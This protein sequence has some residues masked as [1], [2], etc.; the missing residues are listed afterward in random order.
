MGS[1]PVSV[2][3]G[4]RNSQTSAGDLIGD[5]CLHTLH[6]WQAHRK[7]EMLVRTTQLRS[8]HL[9]EVMMSASKQSPPAK[10]VQTANIAARSFANLDRRNGLSE[11]L[12]DPAKHPGVLSYND[13]FV[14][15]KDLY[16]KATVHLLILPRDPVKQNQHPSEAFQDAV[17]FAKLKDEASK[18][19]A[20]AA[21]E[22]ARELCPPT[23]SIPDRN[24]EEE[25]KVGIHSV[26]SMHHLH[27]HVISRD[28]HSPSLKHKKHYNSFNTPFFV[29]LEE[30][31]LTEEEEIA[32]K[33][34]WHKGDMICWR[35]KRNF[36]NKF[37]A[38]KQHLEKEFDEWKAELIKP[39]EG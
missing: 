20:L 34:D 6:R 33:K 13:D 32:R 37:T 2:L 9:V 19:R 36:E 22:L 10:K 12:H 31:P 24:W 7:R 8:K 39:I 3:G 30:F 28:M 5:S 1:A 38:L 4:D 25:I 14:I 16:P 23:M 21:K 29:G 15:I 11:Y 26:P 17:F 18:W 35:C 27:V